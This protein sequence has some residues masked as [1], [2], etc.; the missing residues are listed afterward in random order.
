MRIAAYVELAYR[1]SGG[2]RVY[3]TELIRHL[4]RVDRSNRFTLFTSGTYGD[5]P[6]M[7]VS[8][9]PRFER[10]SLSLSH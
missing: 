4:G 9:N 7:D 8:G 5:S 10:R 2:N 1:H 6:D 3:E